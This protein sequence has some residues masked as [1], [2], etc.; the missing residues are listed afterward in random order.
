MAA[1]SRGRTAGGHVRDLKIERVGPVTVYK[2]G[3]ACYLY[4]RENKQ[5]KRPRID[6]NLAVARIT[7]H[8][9]AKGLAVGQLSPLSF[10]RTTPGE[11]VE[12]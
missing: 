10:R 9:I 7:A 5:T 12:E 3:A 6:G 11:L 1:A 2:R 4:Y 8:E